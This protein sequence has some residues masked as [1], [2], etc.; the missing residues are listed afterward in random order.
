MIQ[1]YDTNNNNT[2]NDKSAINTHTQGGL[3][4]SL[5]NAC[6]VT[7]TSQGRGAQTLLQGS[8][9]CYVLRISY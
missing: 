4:R 8:H 5:V 7:T 9:V 3:A 6:S 2:T 1:N